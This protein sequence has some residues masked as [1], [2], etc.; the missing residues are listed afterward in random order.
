MT[1]LNSIQQIISFQRDLKLF[2]WQMVAEAFDILMVQNLDDSRPNQYTYYP[3]IRTNNTPAFMNFK[4]RQ[5]FGP[6]KFWNHSIF[7]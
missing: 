5:P 2:L 3:P 6:M 7:N 4:V 1:C